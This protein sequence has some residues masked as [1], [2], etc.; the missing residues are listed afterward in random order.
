MFFQI[1]TCTLRIE[2]AKE[3]N[4]IKYDIYTPNKPKQ[5]YPSN[6]SLCCLSQSQHKA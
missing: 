6:N 4:K 5:V 3:K 2:H 1:N